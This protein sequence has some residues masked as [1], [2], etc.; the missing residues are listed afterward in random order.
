MEKNNFIAKENG[1]TLEKHI[2]DVL[3]K[4][5]SILKESGI[6]NENIKK[7]VEISAI[8]HDC[9]KTCSIFQKFIKCGEKE[10]NLTHRHNEIGFAL[11]SFLIDRYYGYNET[12]KQNINLVTNTT[13][14]HHTLYNKETTISLCDYYSIDELKSVAIFFNNLLKKY[15]LDDYIRFK[16]D[17]T[18]E[19]L[20]ENGF[21][22]MNDKI[23]NFI[24]PMDVSKSE[25]KL[26]LKYFEI[27][28]ST[29]R[30]AD[31]KVSEEDFTSNYQR[32]NKDITFK[33][34]KKP[35]HF[36]E[37][38]WNEQ[39]KTAD[40]AFNK[41]NI[42]IIDATMAWGKTICGLKF[43]LHSDKRGFW[44]CP[45]NSLTRTTYNNIINALKDC[46]LN[47][48][49]VALVI[50]GSISGNWGDDIKIED[51]DI[52]VSNIDS[53]L[54]GIV[55]NSRKD[56][57]YE[58]LYSN[59][60]FD[61][62]H[63]YANM[64]TPILPRFI[65]MINAKKEMSNVKTLLLSG[66]VFNTRNYVNIADDCVFKAGDYFAKQK[67]VNLQFIPFED[68][69]EN[70]LSTSD[71][72][73]IST[74]IET[75]QNNYEDGDMDFCYHSAFDDKDLLKI[76]S[77][78]LS[79]NGK[80]ATKERCI[81]SSTSVASRGEDM[82]FRNLF[83]TN[84]RPDQIPQLAGRGGRWNLSEVANYY[85]IESKEKKD[86]AIYRNCKDFTIKD[87]FWKKYYLPHLDHY[88]E[89]ITKKKSNIF[90]QYELVEI[91]KEFV[92]KSG[93]EIINKNYKKGIEDLIQIEFSKG[94][95][96]SDESESKPKYIKES[97]DIRGKSETRFFQYQIDGQPFGV[98][99]GAI[100]TPFY[101]FDTS[102]KNIN[103]FKTKY[104]N[105]PYIMDNII[106]YFEENPD[107]MEKYGIKM[108]KKYKR[109][110]LC[111]KL[112]NL[113]KCS[114]TPF[115]IL[116]G[117]KYNSEIGVYKK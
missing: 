29:V 100:N 65:S 63:E 43:L 6:Y 110:N 56:I 59:C 4:S 107:K 54:N 41:N 8:V 87:D 117:I 74:N 46:N 92:S 112:L 24:N 32:F 102:I 45:D 95:Y 96:I 104:E 90:S 25:Q 105:Y 113:A 84:P 48:I 94:K 99:S 71:S 11:L 15:K 38:R 62:F 61:E 108:I 106:K 77:E 1:T 19:M 23:F 114:E 98:M 47:E 83:I 75:C 91:Y 53:C 69:I 2:D 64:D 55:R 60:I 115:P 57:S 93:T 72:L 58:V 3:V 22:P 28:F 103:D 44:I 35:S 36:D 109:D 70:H 78:I 79:H 39:Y 34:F 111:D 68:Y 26:Q 66:T 67:K 37:V 5:Q 97:M 86:I 73:H 52:I 17:I 27:I 12:V 7:L 42:T 49:R 16:E 30:Y 85:I 76:K 50:S 80:Y 18:E 14:Y 51:A 101:R 21:Q 88:K 9:G 81:T 13:L 40:D 116:C 31:L 82:S 89:I 33:N 20:E 10:S